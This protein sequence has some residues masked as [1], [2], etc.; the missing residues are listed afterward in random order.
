MNAKT[1]AIT[2]GR[3]DSNA[4]ADEKDVLVQA[5]SVRGAL[6]RLGY[7]TVDVPVS[8]DL[9]V[10]AAVIQSASPSFVFNL[11][12][13]IEGKG[14]L[15]G[16]APMLFESIG[17]PYTGAQSEAIYLTSHKLLSKKILAAAGIPT[18][19]W[20]A[21][22]TAPPTGKAAGKAAGRALPR[23]SFPPPYILK[24]VWEHASTGLADSSV[25]SDLKD[26]GPKGLAA[27]LARRASL[28][29]DADMYLEAFIDGREFNLA[30]LSDG[31]GQG[32]AQ[33]LPPAEIRFIGFPEAKPKLVGY[34]AKWDE[35]SFEYVNTPRSFDFPESDR[36]LL[37]A[38]ERIS[39]S[40]WELFDLHGYARV[41]FRVD[42]EG[43]PWVLEINTNPCISPDSGFIAAASQAGFDIDEVV[44]RIVSDI[45]RKAN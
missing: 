3:V 17:I 40:C 21:L 31:T 28:H 10:V 22:P 7:R 9:G 41:D 18:P 25:L 32:T 11:V 44:R 35:E 23:P 30:M 20:V 43:R 38:L 19:P 6:A 33:N 24:S 29:E 27:E 39:R 42:A 15:I 1:V 13:T 37:A 14:R 8:L 2:Y 36:P 34:K 4:P 12:E 45:P 26:P 5:A 16:L